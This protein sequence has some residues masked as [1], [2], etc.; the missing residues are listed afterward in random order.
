MKTTPAVRR[1]DDAPIPRTPRYAPRHI[2]NV[3]AVPQT[4]PHDRDQ[5]GPIPFLML[6]GAWLRAIG[7]S[8]GVQV[9]IEAVPGQITLKTLWRDSS[10]EAQ[11]PEREKPVVRYAEVE[12]R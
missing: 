10:P 5:F 11:A 9:R 6:R 3:R 12:D 4:Q 7:F 2:H 8:V 1:E